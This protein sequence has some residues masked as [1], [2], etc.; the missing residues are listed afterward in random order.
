MTGP[1][2]AGPPPARPDALTSAA[3]ASE[4]ASSGRIPAGSP[5]FDPTVPNAARIYDY[6]LGGKDHFPP[7][8]DAGGRL[9]DT[10]PLIKASVRANREFLI[11]AAGDLAGR[12]YD[13][14]IDLGSGLPTQRN[15]HQV[16]QAVNP[17]ARV[18]YVD[19]DPTV[20]A[21][22]RAILN[23][24]GVAM[25]HGDLRQPDRI[26]DS[27][28]LTELID[29]GRPVVVVAVAVLHFVG[30][31]EDPGAIVA[32]LRARLAPGSRIVI[33]HACLDGMAP[34][35]VAKGVAIYRNTATPITPRSRAEISALLAGCELEEP[36]LVEVSDWKPEPDQPHEDIGDA[37]FVGGVADLHAYGAPKSPAD[38]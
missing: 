20:I 28:I 14:F 1:Q 4:G 6:L 2:P 32:R 13:A 33:S 35:A 26:L 12:G 27:P 9:V 34:E 18:V 10:M 30:D 37:R 15:V 36:G 8:R 23:A 19:H 31:H 29:L 5:V 16:V 3:P 17:D 24:P 11:R 38:P 7:D 21:H 25:L 22:G